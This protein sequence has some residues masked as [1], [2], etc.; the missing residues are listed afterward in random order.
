MVSVAREMVATAPDELKPH[1]HLR[2]VSSTGDTVTV[3]VVKG[4][5][6]VVPDALFY[7][8]GRGAYELLRREVW[9]GERVRLTLAA[10]P[11]LDSRRLVGE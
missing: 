8:R 5:A 3:Q 6:P 2:L 7:V 1:L 10:W 4:R 11:R 9:R